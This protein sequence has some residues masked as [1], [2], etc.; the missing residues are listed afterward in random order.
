MQ[1]SSQHIDGSDALQLY[2]LHERFVLNEQSRWWAYL[3][4]LPSVDDLSHYHPLFFDHEDIDRYLS[5][6]DVRRYILRYQRLCS[7][8]HKALSSDVAVNLVIGCETI[9]DRNKV[10]WP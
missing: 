8:R 10:C 2:L 3:D 9:L 7:E 6:S 1:Q 5:G 4:L